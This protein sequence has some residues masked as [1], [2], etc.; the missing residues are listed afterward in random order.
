[1]TTK[2]YMHSNTYELPAWCYWGT[3]WDGIYLNDELFHQNIPII[4]CV[5]W[6]SV[7]PQGSYGTGQWVKVGFPSFTNGE[8]VR[9]GQTFDWA[10]YQTDTISKKL[11]FNGNP[12]GMGLNTIA[13]QVEVGLPKHYPMSWYVHYIMEVTV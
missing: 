6:I 13:F 12:Y 11:F 8:V 2:W 1:M 5:A 10:A 4:D 3:A 9:V 7:T